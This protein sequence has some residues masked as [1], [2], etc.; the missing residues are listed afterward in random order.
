MLA[1]VRQAIVV[2]GAEAPAED[3][4]EGDEVVVTVGDD[5]LPAV[6]GEEAVAY[7]R[8][9]R[10]EALG[11]ERERAGAGGVAV[12]ALHERPQVELAEQL[13]VHDLGAELGDRPLPGLG[14]ELA[15]AKR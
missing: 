4:E 13:R 9:G 12:E 5:R 7:P 3:D 10:P 1:A 15:A 6:E 2:T 11:R 14:V 8:G